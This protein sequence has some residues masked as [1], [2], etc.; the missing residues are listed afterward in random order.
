MPF[1]VFNRRSVP[2]SADPFL[3]IQKRGICSMNFSAFQALGGT[4]T[5]EHMAVE[6][7]FDR[8][9]RIIGIRKSADAPNSY[10]IRKLD[11]SKSYVLSASAF[12]VY[13]KVDTTAS[14]RYRCQHENGMLTIRLNGQF[15][16]VSGPGR[17]KEM[18]DGAP[19]RAGE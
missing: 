6:L 12:M 10:I 17:H 2:R 1:E 3:T 8:E 4:A 15:A 7:L 11:K 18:R 9:Q 14:K 16:A 5:D 13:Y 19:E